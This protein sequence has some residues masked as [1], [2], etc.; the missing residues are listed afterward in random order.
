MQR[1]AG[2]PAAV[3][4]EIRLIQNKQTKYGGIFFHELVEWTGEKQL[5]E[6]KCHTEPLGNVG[7]MN[8]KVY[9]GSDKAVAG[10]N[11]TICSQGCIQEL[12]EEEMKNKFLSAFDCRSPLSRRK[13]SKSM[14]ETKKRK[15]REQPVL[16]NSSDWILRTE[17][18]K[19]EEGETQI[20]FLTSRR[21]VPPYLFLF[22]FSSIQIAQIYTS[23]YSQSVYSL[24]CLIGK[25]WSCKKW[26]RRTL[27]CSSA[28]ISSSFT[29]S[30]PVHLTFSLTPARKK[31][32]AES[33]NVSHSSRENSAEGS[34]EFDRC[35]QKGSWVTSNFFVSCEWF[36][37]LLL[38]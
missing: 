30:P 37:F 15:K 5:T 6:E 24:H 13:R 20:L 18:G 11:R 3:W 14:K 10:L 4:S 31:E 7:L 35:A 34:A 26:R 2:Q 17:A 19:S 27:K 22:C 36:F 38:Q 25:Q 21:N 28:F 16:H 1:R 9:F 32:E 33:E 12:I 29:T 23:V 8:F